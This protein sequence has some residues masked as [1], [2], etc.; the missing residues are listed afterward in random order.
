M[1]YYRDH[2]SIK[3]IKETY[4]IAEKFHLKEVSSE[5]VKKFI[6]SW[7]KNKS[8]ICSFIPVKVAI[9]SVD[10]YLTTFTDIIKSS[11]RNGTFLE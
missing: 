10:T 1:I 6:K 5:E 9:D 7:N 11:I 4:K 3:N 2:M 8:A